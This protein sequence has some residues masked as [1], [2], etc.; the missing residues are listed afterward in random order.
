MF[1]NNKKMLRKTFLAIILMSGVFFAEASVIINELMPKN[2]SYLMDDKLQYSGWAELYNSGAEAVD[3]T[4]Y[5]LSD[6][7]NRPTKW[8]FESSSPIQ[9]E[10]GNPIDGEPVIIEAGQYLLV[11]LDEVES[12]S[13]YHTNFKLDVENGALYLSDETGTIIDELK[14]DTTYRN[15]SVGRLTDGSAE[16]GTFAVPSPGKS[17]EG[18]KF[19]TKQ[20]EM[21]SFS[22]KPGFYKD[23]QTIEMSVKDKNAKIY[24]TTNGSE[25]TPQSTPYTEPII[26]KKNTPI[27]AAAFVDGEISSKINTA[28][29]FIDEREI[30]IPV[31]AL[32]A[33]P[34]LIYGDSF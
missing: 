32:V 12:F 5:F 6:R 28:S 1:Q 25:P 4:N 34:E 3:I 14:Y 15:M 30:N 21:P 7:T 19:L 29:Y 10:D 16:I 33:E 17:N 2:V 23:A 13:P 20:T 9:D 27:R 22:L 26:I 11:Y 18:G 24:Y 31:V 8:K